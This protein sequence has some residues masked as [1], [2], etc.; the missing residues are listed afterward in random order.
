MPAALYSKEI[1]WHSFLLEAK[2]IPGL[3]TQT[4]GLSRLKNFQRPRLSCGTV[5]QRIAP[6][7]ENLWA[8]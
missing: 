8:K 3:L 2:W 7:H 5:P 1:P 4:E 6:L